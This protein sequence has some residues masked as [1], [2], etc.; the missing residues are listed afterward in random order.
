[1]NGG[2]Q[3]E[4]RLFV[5]LY[6]AATQGDDA[7]VAALQARLLSLGRVYQVGRHA[8]TVIKG[9]KCALSLLGVCDDFMAEPF[10][11]FREPERER[12]RQVLVELGLLS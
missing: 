7:R 1:V 2:A 5:D 11:R 9:V 4:P 10:H 12:V 3:I 6:E 8:S